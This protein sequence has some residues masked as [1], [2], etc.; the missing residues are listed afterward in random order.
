MQLLNRP[1]YVTEEFQYDID[2]TQMKRADWAHLTNYSLAY[3]NNWVKKFVQNVY[4]KHPLCFWA[5]H[6]GVW[7]S[8]PTLIMSNPYAALIQGYFVCFFLNFGEHKSFLWGHWYPCFGLPVMSPLGSKARVGSLICTWQRHRWYRFW[9]S[10]LVWHLPTSWQLAW[11]PVA[12]PHAC[13]SRG[14]M[15]DLIN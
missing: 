14:R 7:V 2:K 3:T 15:P 4:Q 6:C 5:M 11:Q 8:P 1:P 9:D 12:S 13:F 10:P